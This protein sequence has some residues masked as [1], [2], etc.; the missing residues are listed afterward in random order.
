MSFERRNG[1]HSHA[2]GVRG[3]APRGVMRAVLLSCWLAAPVLGQAVTA[4]VGDITRLKGQ[5]QNR[6]VGFGI[7]TGLAQSGDGESYLPAMRSLKQAMSRLG[8]SVERLEDLKGTK[9]AALVSLEAVIPDNGARE[10]D[11]LEVA[12]TALAAKSLEGGR[13]FT[14]PLVYQDPQVEGVFALASGPLIVH[15]RT[16]TR[17]AIRNGAR[18]E[19]DV[20]M[21]VVV[22]GRLLIEQGFA[23]P[24]IE[25]DS[26]YVTLV[27]DEAHSG[28][29][30]AA[31]VAEAIHQD[32]QLSADV[33]RVA[34]A[35]DPKNVVVLVPH[36]QESDP[37][38]W[39][40]SVEL[41]PLLMESSEA[42]VT[43]NRTSGTIVVTG[44]TR[45]SSVVVS[46]KGLTITVLTPLP[47]GS[48]P[49]PIYE[50]QRFVPVDSAGQRS[51]N[52]RDLLEAL[53]RLKVEF[54][55]RVAIL[56]EIHR[57]G[58]LHATL[59]YEG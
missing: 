56:E 1:K 31:A 45:I 27:L 50:E 48:V 41:A 12:V 7:V 14:A 29:A 36:H 55:D 43:I 17:A 42:R 47:D 35:M 24:W 6:L 26:K 53:N 21:N 11:L 49:T 22:S 52:V 46:Q 44:D 2:P 4:R 40:R 33:E 8:V 58:K 15:P 38:S 20:F 13:L 10:G 16:P 32:L 57:A 51:P 18:M 34:R 59:M 30:M 23:N 28:W 39:I 19:R 54:D 37:V 25:P 5:G 9:N 3:A